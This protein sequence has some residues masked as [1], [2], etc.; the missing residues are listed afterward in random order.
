MGTPAVGKGMW[1]QFRE[2]SPELF[3]CSFYLFYLTRMEDRTSTIPTS[4]TGLYTMT[5]VVLL[6]ERAIKQ[7][8]N[9][10]AG[11]IPWFPVSFCHLVL[12]FG[13]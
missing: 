4:T 1:A 8:R 10:H 2:T 11:T 12:I 6:F 5:K 3:I 13:T 9:K 7:F